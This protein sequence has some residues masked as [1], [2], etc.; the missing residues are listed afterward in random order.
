MGKNKKNISDYD[1][2]YTDIV[3]DDCWKDSAVSKETIR[4]FRWTADEVPKINYSKNKKGIKNN[5]K[6]SI[7]SLSEAENE[8]I[9]IW[10]W[11]CLKATFLIIVISLI[12][13]FLII[14]AFSWRL[15]LITF[16][17]WVIA[18]IAFLGIAFIKKVD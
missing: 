1:D 2:M 8:H 7:R 9:N 6:E 17:I 12:L 5:Q 10:L 14:K 11:N 16:V 18:M 3:W 4:N 13:R 15:L